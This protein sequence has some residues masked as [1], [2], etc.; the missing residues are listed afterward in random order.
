MNDAA[1]SRSATKTVRGMGRTLLRGDV[2]WISYYFNGKEVRE[3]SKSRNET[4]ARRL[5]KKRLQEIHG[6]RF[7]GPQEEKLSVHELLDALITH[8]E[9][10]GAKTVQRL[11]SHL[12]PLR[13]KFTLTRAINVTTA[14]VESYVAERL[15]LGKARATVNREIGALKQALNLARKQARLTRVPYIPMLREEMPDKGS[16][17]TPILRR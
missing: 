8:L 16:S 11:K 1:R 9:T 15:K 12:T 10:K 6:N 4:N 7:T 3:S 13:E 17:S 14:A 5:L 2:W